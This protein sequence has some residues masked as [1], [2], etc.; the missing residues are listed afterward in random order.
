MSNAQCAKGKDAL[1]KSNSEI[2]LI[3]LDSRP[4]GGFK[5]LGNF[6]FVCEIVSPFEA[7]LFITGPNRG[8][9]REA[10]QMNIS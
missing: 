2:I 10:P 7:V 1:K 9:E 3:D 5:T 6:Q 4:A 8:V